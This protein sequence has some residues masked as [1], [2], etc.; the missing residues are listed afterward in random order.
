MDIVP[1]LSSPIETLTKKEISPLSPNIETLTK[2]EVSLIEAGATR[3]A[4]YEAMVSALN[5]KTIALDK[6]GGEH[7]SPDHATRIRA[8]EMISKLH[9]DLKE[10]VVDNRV[11]NVA[12]NVTAGELATFCDMVKDV[13]E[14]LANLSTNGK[15]TGEVIDITVEKT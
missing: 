9:G 4:A 13:Q 6:F 3:K 8:A 2:K 15:Q 11:V 1:T 7:E 14:Q 12:L 10:N 5:A